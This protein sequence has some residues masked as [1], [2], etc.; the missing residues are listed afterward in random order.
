MIFNWATPLLV[1]DLSAILG[2]SPR[3]HT[4][5]AQCCSGEGDPQGPAH[6]GQLTLC[7]G[8]KEEETPAG[9]QKSTIG[10]IKSLNSHD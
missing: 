2:A 1:F 4:K 6:K 7:L 9:W 3:L 10:Q 8:R 5:F